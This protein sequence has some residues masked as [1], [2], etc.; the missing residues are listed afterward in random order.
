VEEG[1]VEEFLDH[2]HDEGTSLIPLGLLP[3]GESHSRTKD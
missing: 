3:D 2:G 1:P